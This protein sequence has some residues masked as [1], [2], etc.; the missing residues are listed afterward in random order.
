ML[1]ATWNGS[2]AYVYNICKMVTGFIILYEDW[3]NNNMIIGRSH[4][5]MEY[6]DGKLLVVG[7]YDADG[8]TTQV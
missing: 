5:T 2:T 1:Q 6:V 4:H 7:G 8:T 3:Y